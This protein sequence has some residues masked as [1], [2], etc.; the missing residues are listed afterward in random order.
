MTLSIIF[1]GAIYTVALNEI[2]SRITNFQTNIEESLKRSENPNLSL[3]MRYS[4]DLN[5]SD[6]LVANLVLVNLFVLVGGGI[7]SYFLAIRSL[8]PIKKVHESQSR[9]TS[10]ASHELRTPLAVMKTE[11]EVVLR[12]KSATT[13]DLKQVLSSNLEEVNKLSNLAEM[14]LGL[15]RIDNTKL[16]FCAVNI[17]KITKNV[18]KNLKYNNKQVVL[19]SSGQYI[20]YGNEMALLDLVKVLVDNAIKFSPKKS[21]IKIVISKQESDYV[22]FKITNT[23]PGIQSDKIP[24]IF[25]RFYRSDTSR[26]NTKNKGYGLG[27]ALAKKIVESHNGDISV[28]SKPDVKTTFTVLLPLNKKHIVTDTKN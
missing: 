7:I 17:N 5:V 10:D 1:S 20:V 22:K 9:F 8:I 25:D 11:L 24:Y 18:I 12:D 19:S 23:G 2:Q 21:N 14:L 27:L 28:V 15:S 4:D 3:I 6:K 13:E 16:K 26:T